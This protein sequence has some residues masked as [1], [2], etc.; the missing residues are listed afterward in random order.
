MQRSS[1]SIGAL[2]GALAKA[3]ADL[4]RARDTSVVERVR[5][6]LNQRKADLGKAQQDVNR[7]RPLVQARAIP[8]QDLDTALSQEKVA[9][10][11]LKDLGM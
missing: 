1:E 10:A 11:G 2:A 8:Q 9:Q 5:A 7:Y 4:T 6:T 3:Q